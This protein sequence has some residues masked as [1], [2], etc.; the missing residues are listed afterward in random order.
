[1]SITLSATLSLSATDGI[2]GNST[3]TKSVAGLAFASAS[4]LVYDV[5]QSIGTTPV[6][7][8]LPITPVPFFYLKNTSNVT[9]QIVTVNVTPAVLLS[10]PSSPSLSQSSGGTLNATTYYVKTTYVNQFGE[11]SGSVEA[12]FAAAANNVLVVTSP[13]ASGTGAGVATGYNVYVSNSS[14]TET[15]QNNSVV[16]IG[17]SWTEPTSGLLTNGSAVTVA[18]TAGGNQGTSV[19]SRILL[20]GSVMLLVDSSSGGGIYAVSLQSNQ[21]GVPVEYF[22]GA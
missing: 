12:N 14:G 20:P 17:T 18:N 10:A 21:A 19:I 3:L 8:T 1:M 6:S 9:G 4:E 11:T 15:K 7:L 2:T 13:S 22:T 5:L 16:P